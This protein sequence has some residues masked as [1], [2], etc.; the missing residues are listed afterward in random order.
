MHACTRD[1]YDT[2]IFDDSHK[3]IKDFPTLG[4]T[5]SRGNMDLKRNDKNRILNA[6]IEGKEADIKEAVREIARIINGTSKDEILHVDY[7]GNQGLLTWYFPARLWNALRTVSTDYSICSAEGH[8]AIKLH[9]GSSL[10]ALPEDFIKAKAVVFWGSEAAFSFIH[11][12]KLLANKRK[13]TIDVRLS[14]TAKRSDR[15]YIIKPSSDAFLALGIIK[16]LIELGLENPL[17]DDLQAL[18]DYVRAYDWELIENTTGLKKEEIKELSI[19]YKEEKPLTII[20]FAL[21]RTYNGGH[22]ISL[23]S[24]IPALIGL[25]YGFYYSN[26]QGF[27]IDFEYLR[28]YHLSKPSR[29]VNMSKIW[30]EVEEG[31]IKVIFTWNANP[32]HSLPRWDVIREKVEEGEVKLIVHDPFWSETAK[33]ANIVIPAPTYLE[34]YDVVYSYWHDY[35]IYNEPIRDAKGIDEVR[36]MRM[37]AEELRLRHPLIEEDEWDAVDRAISKTGISLEELRQKKVVKIKNLNRG[38]QVAKVLPLPNLTPP[39]ND[40]Y[41]LVFSSHPNHT[42]SQFK[43]LFNTEPIVYNC[44]FDGTGFLENEKGRVKVIFRKSEGVPKNVLFM[45]KSSLIDLEGKPINSICNDTSNEYGK[46]PQLNATIIRK[47][48]ID[49]N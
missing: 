12:W 16:Y 37:I 20:G 13:V 21:G 38:Y 18:Q 49:K 41:Y 7:D 28:G 48:I 34:K 42:N 26:S 1:C 9:Y 30:K 31:K 29:I 46:T 36:L 19:F 6:Y 43:E 24:L 40:D 22:A 45:F 14:E 33:I 3:P 17:I 32:Y 5:C 2:C 25:R 23:I 44:C 8:N 47:V 27:N 10:G 39:P 11:G 35:L 15:V 4:F